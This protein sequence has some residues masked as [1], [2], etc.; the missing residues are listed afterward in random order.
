MVRVYNHEWANT[1]LAKEALGNQS[2]KPCK[3]RRIKQTIAV[4]ASMGLI[5][6]YADKTPTEQL[7]TDKNESSC[8]MD[9]LLEL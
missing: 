1:S 2:L 4:V 5:C 7:C 3:F 6:H 9:K 8:G